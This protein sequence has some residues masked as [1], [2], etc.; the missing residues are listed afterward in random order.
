MDYG[1]SSVVGLKCKGEG[2]FCI[3]I[4]GSTSYTRYSFNH[5]KLKF[6]DRLVVGLDHNLRTKLLH[7]FY[8]PPLGGHFGVRAHMRGST[9][10][11][12][13]HL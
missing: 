2:S 4:V 6:N 12:S 3:N 11:F 13:G 5:G 7:E 8:V 10:I 1:V 9:N